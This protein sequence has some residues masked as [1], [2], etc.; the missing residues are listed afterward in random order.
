MP[1]DSL[2]LKPLSG[3]RAFEEISDQIRDLIFSK[4]LK[5]GDK[6]PPERKLAERFRAGRTAVREGLRILEQSGL[7]TVKQGSE[8]GSFIR[9]VSTSVVAGFL[10]DVIRRAD[11]RLGHLTEVRIG[12]EKLVIGVAMPRITEIELGLLK[13]HI[14][15]AETIM[16]E[17]FR[18]GKRLNFK[19]WA[20]S[21]LQF[22]IVLARATRNP[23]YEMI[24]ESLMNVS[25]TFLVDLPIVPEF[26][27]AHVRDHKGIYDAVKD[28]DLRLAERRLEE[29]S[30]QVERSLLFS[31]NP[32]EKSG[33]SQNPSWCG[34]TNDPQSV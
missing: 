30:L 25:R 23:L 10:S 21:N 11:V 15:D 6:L 17:S 27:E 24:L 8:G 3:K 32:D 33:D 1:N 9:D 2:R 18:Q 20:E 4:K 12:I 16:G 22:H 31:L 29:H 28:K 7:I 14:D 13:K 26:V 5:P 34:G 19:L